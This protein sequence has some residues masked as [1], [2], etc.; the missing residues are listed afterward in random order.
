MAGRPPTYQSDDAQP[1]SISLRVPKALYDQAHQYAQQR[2]MSMTELLLDGLTMRLETSVDPREL[3][4]SDESNTV[5]LELHEELKA[6]LLDELR[7]DVQRLLTSTT[8][9]PASVPSDIVLLNGNTILQNSSPQPGFDATKYR[10]G[11]LCPQ[12]HEYEG[13]GRSLRRQKQG[14]CVECGKLAKR[15]KRQ[16]GKAREAGLPSRTQKALDTVDVP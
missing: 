6:T 9:M 2:R 7:R 5:M 11:K 16:R 1:V 4:S 3:L 14:D 13:T 8:H 15:Q 10:L 12:G